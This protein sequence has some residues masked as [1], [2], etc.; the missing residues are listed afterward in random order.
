LPQK[1]EFDID[2]FW[3]KESGPSVFWQTLN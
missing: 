3:E 2:I 1:I